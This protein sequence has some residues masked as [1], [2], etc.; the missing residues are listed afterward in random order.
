VG[1]RI[2]SPPVDFAGM[3]RA[4]G[5]HGEGPVEDPAL[6]A[7]ALE[8]ALRVVKEEQRPAVVDVVIH[9]E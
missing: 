7:P 6:I 8:R 2:E 4:F 5:A 1:I 9:P 3:A